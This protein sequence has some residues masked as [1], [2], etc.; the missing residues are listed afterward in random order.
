MYTTKQVINY[1]KKNPLG[2]A[3][4]KN[5]KNLNVEVFMCRD[6]NLGIWEIG[7]GRVIDFDLSNF[8]NDLWIMS[9]NPY[10]K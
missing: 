2:K 7:D 3:E 1:Y 8:I 4:F 10:K 6:G 5:Y 9:I